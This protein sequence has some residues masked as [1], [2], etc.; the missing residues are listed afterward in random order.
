MADDIREA[1]ERLEES[2]AYMVVPYVV[3]AIAV[4]TIADVFPYEA[5]ESMMPGDNFRP[6]EQEEQEA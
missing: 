3:S 5:S 2:L 6:L 1:L 4:S